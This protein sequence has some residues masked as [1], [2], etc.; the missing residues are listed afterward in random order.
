MPPPLTSSFFA[1]TFS[2]FK[3]PDLK[4]YIPREI[5]G[6]KEALENIPPERSLR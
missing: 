1:N 3:S 6:V 2:S 5:T 4:E